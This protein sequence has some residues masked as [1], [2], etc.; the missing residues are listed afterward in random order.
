MKDVFYRVTMLSSLEIGQNFMYKN[1]LFKKI[2]DADGVQVGITAGDFEN[3]GST[4]KQ[5]MA[6]TDKSEVLVKVN[7][8]LEIEEKVK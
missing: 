8:Q 1:T 3:N 7:G 5:V 2:Y 4:G 6:F